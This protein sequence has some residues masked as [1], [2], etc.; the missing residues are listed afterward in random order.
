MKF[1]H[2]ADLHLD[3]RLRGLEAY[4][5]APVDEIRGATRR[6]V[7]NLVE[8]CLEEEAA[9]LV[10]AGDL[11][12]GDWRDYNTGLFFLRQVTRLL[13]EG[14]RVAWVRG[15]HDA[16]SQIT[17]ALTRPRARSS[18]RREQLAR[19][20]SR[21]SVSRCT[22]RAT[23]I[24]KSRPIS[25][26]ATPSPCPT[27]STW[28][29]C[30]HGPR[31]P[32]G[33]RRLRP[34]QHVASRRPRL[35]LLG[36]R[37]RACLRGR[38]AGSSIVFPGNLQ[39]RYARGG[40][41]GGDGRDGRGRSAVGE[42]EHRVLDVVRWSVRPVD[43]PEAASGSEVVERVRRRWTG[44][45]PRRRIVTRPAHRAVGA[46]WRGRC[47]AALARTMGRRDPAAGGGLGR[48]GLA[49]RRSV[50]DPP[51]R[52]SGARSCPGIRSRARPRARRSDRQSDRD[53]PGERG[54]R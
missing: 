36:A 33:P 42:P 39:G 14:V 29:S 54:G 48:A 49:R 25:R 37:P 1:V 19:S 31:R 46:T 6:A 44:R 51:G 50:R 53:R 47:T 5:G 3:K 38:R 41:E 21:I 18:S 30:I 15:N 9:L 20:A 4:E 52:R 45:W 22:D 43:A 12:D 2:A 40:A 26:R 10:I 27:S 23:A 17:K 28:A 34:D 32:P 35:R 8:L 11:Y 16:A 13:R 24:A 7:S